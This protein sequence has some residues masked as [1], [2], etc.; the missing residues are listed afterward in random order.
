MMKGGAMSKAI[1]YVRV[2]KDDQELG[3]EAQ[4]AELARWCEHNGADLVAV[5]EDL[6]VSG[7]AELDKRPALLAAVDALERGAVLLVAK[8]DRLARDPMVAAMVERLA[9]RKGASVVSTAGEGNGDTPSDVLMRRMVDAFAEYERLVIKARTRAAL[10]VKRARGEAYG[11]TPFGYCREGDR[12]VADTEA[13]EAIGLILELRADGMSYRAIAAELVRRG[14]P[15][16]KGGAWAAKTVRSITL[17]A[18]A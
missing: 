3:P 18:A 13:Q 7:G 16:A 6:G 10:A 5:H 17:R 2:S 11:E 12:L 9:E 8:R 15:T 1:G 4:R 14:V